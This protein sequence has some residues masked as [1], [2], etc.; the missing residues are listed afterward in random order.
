MW[1]PKV[2]GSQLGSLC[3]ISWRMSPGVGSGIPGVVRQVPTWGSSV[4]GG[5]LALSEGDTA[6]QLL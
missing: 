2:P 1:E 6:S 4:S 3:K 5:D